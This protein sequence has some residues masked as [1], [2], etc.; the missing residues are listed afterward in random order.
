MADAMIMHKLNRVEKLTHNLLE[1]MFIIL[2]CSIHLFIVKSVAIVW[3]SFVVWVALVGMVNNWKERSSWAVFHNKVDKL[4]VLVN[5]EQL[6]KVPHSAWGVLFFK[7]LLYL[8]KVEN[9]IRQNLSLNIKLRL[10]QCLDGKLL[11]RGVWGDATLLQVNILVCVL[12]G[13]VDSFSD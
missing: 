7:G 5:F 6:V 12:V 3:A 10:V 9:F 11:L 2:V 13:D 4:I 1:K 8:Y